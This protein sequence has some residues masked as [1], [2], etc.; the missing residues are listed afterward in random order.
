VYHLIFHKKW[1]GD[2]ELST[3]EHSR[4]LARILE[5]QPSK[6]PTETVT[7][8]LS[9]LVARQMLPPQEKCGM[10]I[11]ENPSTPLSAI[12]KQSLITQLPPG[13]QN[14]LF[15]ICRER[16][17]SHNQ[18][19]TLHRLL[20]KDGLHVVGKLKLTPNQRV[21]VQDN[22]RGGNWGRGPYLR[23]G[24]GPVEIWLVWDSFPVFKEATHQDVNSVLER[25][26]YW[27]E[28]INFAWSPICHSNPLHTTD[29]ISE[30]LELL[31]AIGEKGSL[32][33]ILEDV[34][35]KQ[36][37]QPPKRTQSMSKPLGRSRVWSEQL[38]N[39]EEVVRK[40]FGLGF[41]E[42]LAREIGFYNQFRDLDIVPK[43]IDYD[44]QSIV[45]PKLAPL[46]SKGE[47]ARSATISLSPQQTARV[48]KF[49]QA[50]NARNFALVDFTPENLLVNESG[51]IQA[52]DFEFCQ[53]SKA[54]EAWYESS[55]FRGLP[56]HSKLDRPN[57]WT[58]GLD[59]WDIVWGPA[60]GMTLRK[61]ARVLR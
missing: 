1:L 15:L 43:L 44:F 32:F 10:L 14:L 6:D 24:G 49:I 4:I 59:H 12:M 58:Y 18:E 35:D 2:V 60:T 48:V 37:R 7:Q 50:V 52:I 56:T 28:E 42:Y 29:G 3:I 36:R 21:L 31:E 13:A 41:E 8:T 5:L 51:E 39:G 19:G 54:P 22:S 55:D 16:L 45:I 47:N 17:F 46:H 11:R 40:T 20:T 61:L 23:S 57:G 30:G 34:S 9:E 26:S 53:V 27:R 33:A 38:S 25:K